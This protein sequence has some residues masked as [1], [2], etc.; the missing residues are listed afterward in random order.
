MVQVSD[1]EVEEPVTP[2]PELREYRIQIPPLNKSLIDKKSRTRQLFNFLKAR[3]SMEWFKKLRFCNSLFFFVFFLFLVDRIAF[4]ILGHKS[5]D[6]NSI[7][8]SIF[9]ETFL[10]EIVM[11]FASR[12]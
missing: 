11:N 10:I 6:R 12:V 4:P 5:L 2:S 9:C 7:I 8:S 3:P 1:N